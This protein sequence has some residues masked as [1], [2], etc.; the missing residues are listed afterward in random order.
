MCVFWWTLRALITESARGLNGFSTNS[1]WAIRGASSNPHHGPDV[2]AVAVPR[3]GGAGRHRDRGPRDARGRDA[4]G[5]AVMEREILAGEVRRQQVRHQRRGR[6]IRTHV[7]RRLRLRQRVLVRQSVWPPPP[8][9][10][11]PRTPRCP[12]RRI[13]PGTGR[14]GSSTSTSNGIATWAKACRRC[15]RPPGRGRST[16]RRRTDRCAAP[17]TPTSTAAPAREPWKCPW[18]RFPPG[19]GDARSNPV[20]AQLQ[21]L[22]RRGRHRGDV[23]DL[24]PGRVSAAVG[25]DMDVGVVVGVIRAV[26]RLPISRGG[27]VRW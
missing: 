24:V 25:G 6:S 18:R 9:G 5:A 19:P 10:P 15:G 12:S 20:V 16:R 7:Q 8:M 11:L 26:I 27:R 4:R 22:L 23:I 3:R 1:W 21:S 2:Q 17:G 14:G 13:T